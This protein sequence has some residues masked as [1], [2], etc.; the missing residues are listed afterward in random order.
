MKTTTH[1]TQP[2]AAG[3]AA[4]TPLPYRFQTDGD[5][6]GLCIVSEFGRVAQLCATSEIDAESQETAAFI[7]TACNSHAR[8]LADKAALVAALLGAE[9]R[10]AAIQ[11]DGH[12]MSHETLYAYALEGAN[13]A[14]A[15]LQ[16]AKQGGES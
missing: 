2:P 4:H 8:L 1:P 6:G 7:V 16:Q 5:F 11:L 9:N 10:L 14:R 3:Q 15:A 13:Q 12:A